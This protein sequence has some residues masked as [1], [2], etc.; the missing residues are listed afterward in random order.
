MALVARDLA[1]S[2]PDAS[3]LRDQ[4]VDLTW[5]ELD[6][7]LNRAVNALSGWPGRVA[8]MADN[9]AD[10][11]L[12]HTA[13][14]LSGVSAVPVS[15]HLTADEATYLLEVSGA[16]LVLAGPGTVGVARTAAAAVGAQLLA[17]RGDGSWESFLT[18]SSDAEP[19]SSHGPRPPLMFTSG[20]TGRP[21]A[22]EIPPTMFPTA[23]DIPGLL[24]QIAAH[25]L[26]G[27][28]R[29]LVVGPLHHTGP[30]TAARLLAVGNPVTVLGRFDAA[31]LLEVATRNAIATSVMVPTHF[32]RLLAL[33][34]E[35][36]AGFDP[37]ALK[38]VAQ[39]GAACPVEVK[40][41]M[42]DWW[43]P[44]LTESYGATEVGVVA[45]IDSA[46]WLEHPGSVGCAVAPFEVVVRDEDG[47][48]V[49]AGQTGELWFRDSTGRGVVYMH[50]PDDAVA[51]AEEPGL[52][53]LG[54]VGH[55]DA[56]GYLYI[57]DRVS[58]LVVSGGVNV[59]PAEA[60]QALS[61]HPG[62]QDSGGIGVPDADLGERLVLLVQLTDPH[63]RPEDLMAW[64]RARIAHYKCPRE[65]V[66]V[67]ELPRTTMGKLDK[68]ALRRSYLAGTA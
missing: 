55:V 29:H 9:S 43:G 18:G 22:T 19:L 57:T 41:Q 61:D 32:V 62:V 36:R 25:P 68:R 15:A 2:T 13:L 54:E 52:F 47:S 31:R 21:K 64:I 7:L 30:L 26:H 60:E 66:V 59:Y 53:T 38:Q 28:G 67:G 45:S 20:T 56:D 10:T 49:A 3:A 44:V 46:A 5:G 65:V 58:D 63:A 14:L 40:R 23:A 8:V 12:A 1:A 27:L 24:E 37:S 4:H 42:I 6:L 35:V 11:L 33:P 34:D 51:A 39:T 48:A 50:V 16:T 17:W